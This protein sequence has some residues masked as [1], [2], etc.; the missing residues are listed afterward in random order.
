MNVVAEML[1]NEPAPTVIWATLT[2]LTLPALLLL[3]SPS[4]VRNP[5]Q[6]ARDVVAVLRERGELRRLAAE[7]AAQTTRY[8]EE[9]RVAADRAATSSERWQQRWQQASDELNA[10][11]QAWLDADA[12]LRA[13][14]AAAAWG[15]PWSVRTCEEYAARERYL[16]HTVAAAAGRGDL[17]ADAVADALAGRNGWDARLHPV[18][19]EL[20]I[21]RAS[22]AWLRQ[23]YER[24]AVAERAAW[25][26][27]ELARRSSD[28][29]RHEAAFTAVQSWSVAGARAGA[30]AGARQAVTAAL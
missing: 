30:G 15:A 18:E 26:D 4:G 21:G 5:R 27:A 3:G 22:V 6:A 10:A 17:P 24:A 20:V 13:G 23:R 12:R 7:E 16:H 28:S 1:L 8:A 25:H 2:L 11:W 19:Q 29:L 14:V 9:V